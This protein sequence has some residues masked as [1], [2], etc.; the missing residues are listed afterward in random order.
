LEPL[1]PIVGGDVVTVARRFE[2]DCDT[3]QEETVTPLARASK[4]REQSSWG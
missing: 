4:S 3:L 1:D 2:S